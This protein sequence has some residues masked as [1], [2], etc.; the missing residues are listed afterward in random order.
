MVIYIRQQIFFIRERQKKRTDACSNGKHP[1]HIDNED[2]YRVIRSEKHRYIYFAMSE[3]KRKHA[4][5]ALTYSV[6]PYPKGA[7]N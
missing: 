1:R 5:K 3:R 6:L 7:N 2:V 4:M